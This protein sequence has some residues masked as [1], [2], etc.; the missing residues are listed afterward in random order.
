MKDAEIEYK[1]DTKP[2]VLGVNDAAR[3]A[4][5]V[6]RDFEARKRFFNS[7]ITLIKRC[8]SIVFI[9]IILNASK[10]HSEYL[11]DIEFDN[12]Y[13]TPYFRKIDARRKARGSLTLLPLKKLEKKK[14]IDPYDLHQSKAER[15]NL[16]GQT[17]KLLLEVI[18]ASTFV[19]LDRL[20]FEV[21]DIVRK[22]AHLEIT[23]VR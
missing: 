18:T 14:L 16:L 5:G 22:H 4:A 9:R 20:L 21:L 19:L 3:A 6:M 12:V 2:I 10:Y 15:R 17:A 8:L 7:V 13:I 11:S 1:V 23:Q